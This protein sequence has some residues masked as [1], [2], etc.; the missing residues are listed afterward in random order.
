MQIL[1]SHQ[2][3]TG[4][5]TLGVWPNNPCSHKP[6]RGSWCLVK[7]ENLYSQKLMTSQF[8]KLQA[9]LTAGGSHVIP[10]FPTVFNLGILWEAAVTILP[11]WG[12]KII[13]EALTL[14]SVLTSKLLVMWKKMPPTPSCNLRHCLGFLL[15]K[16]ISH[17]MTWFKKNLSPHDDKNFKQYFSVEIS[18]KYGAEGNILMDF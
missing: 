17:C 13:V 16:H 9:S 1:K 8:P 4:S 11:S 6:S 7:F 15:A 18:I 14:T 5:E 10:S 12:N 2:R 3:P